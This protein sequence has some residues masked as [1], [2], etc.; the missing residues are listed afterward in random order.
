MNLEVGARSHLI[1]DDLS[2]KQFPLLNSLVSKTQ[3]L[4]LPFSYN[5][6][7]MIAHGDMEV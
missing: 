4:R 6:I 5:T 3:P 7:L 1:L 2:A